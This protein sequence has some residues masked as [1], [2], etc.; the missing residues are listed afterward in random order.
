MKEV[1]A[2]VAKEVN[3]L[4]SWSWKQEEGDLLCVCLEHPPSDLP[5]YGP[6][7]KPFIRRKTE[8]IK[9]HADEARQLISCSSS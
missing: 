8:D 5:T 1:A 3:G 2:V 4:F 9:L 7:H 6:T